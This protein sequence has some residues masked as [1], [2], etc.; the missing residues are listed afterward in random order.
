MAFRS[1]SKPQLARKTIL[2]LA[3]ATVNFYDQHYKRDDAGKILMSPAQSLETYQ[4]DAVNPT[5]D[6]A[7]LMNILPRLLALPE[8]A[9]DARQ[10][11]TWKK[12]LSDLP[13]IPKGT[14]LKGKIPRRGGGDANG[15]AVIL[16]AQKY[17]QTKNSENPELYTVLPYR[18]YGVGKPDLKLA[19]DTFKARLFPQ[20]TCWG[21]DGAQ[22]ANLGLTR[23]AKRAATREF[24]QYGNQHFKWFW[25]KGHDWTPDVDNGG[26]GMTTLQEMIMQCDGKRIQLIPAWPSDWTADFKLNAPFRTTVE[27]H[28]ENGKITNLKVTPAEREKDIVVVVQ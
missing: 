2:P 22:A 28:V 10:R 16:P 4:E 7:G 18:L 13:A 21:Q 26:S 9:S 12:V 17:G 27:A 8:G 3:D 25:T 14:T 24:T 20:D 19:V 11:E 23:E 1:V 15:D 5:P 6:I